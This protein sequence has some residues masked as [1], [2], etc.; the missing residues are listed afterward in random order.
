MGLDGDRRP[1][2]CQLRR[3]LRDAVGVHLGNL[4][5]GELATRLGRHAVADAVAGEDLREVMPEVAA[6]LRPAWQL[7]L[8][9]RAQVRQLGPDAEEVAQWIAPSWRADLRDLVFASLR[10]VAA[11]TQQGHTQ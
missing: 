8:E 4:H 2:G 5:T 3:G 9:V 6:S 10:C 11:V 7:V 1:H